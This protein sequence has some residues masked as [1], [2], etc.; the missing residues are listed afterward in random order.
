MSRDITGPRLDAERSEMA[1][2]PTVSGTRSM[3]APPETSAISR[4]PHRPV[5]VTDAALRTVTAQLAGVHVHER[6]HSGS[7]VESDGRQTR[8]PV[9]R[10]L[11]PPMSETL[12]RLRKKRAQIAARS[13]A[14]AS[15]PSF[16]DA[17]GIDD[18][19]LGAQ[20]LRFRELVAEVA[21]PNAA[22]EYERRAKL[23]K[24]LQR[25]A[26][27]RFRGCQA[28]V[29][30]STA[31]GV[32]LRG[33]DLDI[34]FVAPM[35]PLEVLRAERHDERY[36]EDDF[37]RDVVG[38]LGRLLRRRRHEFENVQ[39]I[40]QTRVPLVKFHDLRSDIEVDVQVNNSFVARNT[41][42]LRAYVRFDPRV[43]PLA[44]FVKRWAVARDLN[45]PFAGTL[46]SYSYLILLIQYLQLVTPPVLPCLQRL[47]LRRA[48][49]IA[50]GQEA[51]AATST[52]ASSVE[53]LVEYQQLEE[54]VDERLVDEHYLERDDLRMPVHN[55]MPEALLLAGFFYFYGYQFDYENCA[56]SVRCGRLIDK[57]RRGWAVDDYGGSGAATAPEGR[58]DEA[59]LESVPA[60]AVEAPTTGA[61]SDNNK[62]RESTGRL[63]DDEERQA[64]SNPSDEE[65][66]T[67]AAMTANADVGRNAPTPPAA[68]GT[69]AAAADPQLQRDAARRQ[70]Q[71]RIREQMDRS[72]RH[73]FSIEDPFDMTHDLG[74]VCSKASAA[75]LR[76]EFRRAYAVLAQRLPLESLLKPY[77][78][79]EE[80]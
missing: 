62:A 58:A 68:N 14:V 6:R 73:F 45:E 47:A 17:W 25:V 52:S 77:D 67:A 4:R 80:N 46:S 13:A 35:P 19:Y 61:E 55:D 72:Q 29:Y 20:A 41:A 10:S 70:R 71:R 23:A 36:S 21:Y 48:A 9:E 43:R 18:E 57:R 33:G 54:I 56:V 11:R 50:H 79:A 44:I 38:D 24:H 37:R 39:I 66:P 51:A 8:Y 78:Y 27:S 30:G 31:T 69:D 28:R 59:G 75:L 16:E 22:A 64:L 15:A 53:E 49:T 26:D 74:R 42:L 60:A 63:S 7:D 12:E 1:T 40:A 32:L 5:G 3:G 34:N 65:N 2:G 76:H